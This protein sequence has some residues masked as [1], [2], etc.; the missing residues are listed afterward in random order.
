MSLVHSSSILFHLALFSYR[1]LNPLEDLV[2][3]ALHP[4]L[5]EWLE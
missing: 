1:R 4:L 3:R 5:K 2:R